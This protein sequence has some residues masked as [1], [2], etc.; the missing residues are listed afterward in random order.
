[1]EETHISVAV[2]K[3]RCHRD[4][5]G[6]AY[7]DQSAALAAAAADVQDGDRDIYAGTPDEM[8]SLAYALEQGPTGRE[9][10]Y[11]NLRLAEALRDAIMDESMRRD[12][13]ERLL[14]VR[15][16]MA[17]QDFDT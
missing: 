16:D 10:R 15:A 12:T 14:D 6:R 9:P 13:A 8:A 17:A 11:Y 1:M 3:L 5:R 4:L 7:P 2:Y